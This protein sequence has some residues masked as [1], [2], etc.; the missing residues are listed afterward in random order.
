MNINVFSLDLKV[1]RVGASLKGD[2]LCKTHFFRCFYM[3][4]CV[5]GLPPHTLKRKFRQL[6]QCFVICRVKKWVCKRAVWISPRLWRNRPGDL[7][8]PALAPGI[9]AHTSSA[10]WT[11]I[12]HCVALDS[13]CTGQPDRYD[14]QP[15]SQALLLC[16]RMHGSS[17][18]AK[19]W[20]VQI[21]SLGCA[22]SSSLAC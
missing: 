2:I 11:R 13:L 18:F 9:S 8:I 6:S 17:R 19:K 20:A 22:C 5:S 21:P 1:V 3:Y 4:I 15:E 7:N 16:R 12:R 10:T 14:V